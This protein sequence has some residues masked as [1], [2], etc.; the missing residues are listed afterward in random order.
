MTDTLL[1]DVASQVLDAAA[2]ALT[3]QTHA[4]QDLRPAIAVVQVGEQWAWDPCERLVVHVAGL[5]AH[6]PIP[7]AGPSTADLA[8]SPVAVPVADLVVTLLYAV[9][10]IE[11]TGKL[12]PTAD[13]TAAAGRLQAGAMTLWRGVA[14]ARRDGT[15]AP[16]LDDCDGAQLGRL[17]PV[18]PAGGYAGWELPVRLNLGAAS[19]SGS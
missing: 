6:Q 5:D 19:A 3:G 13:I 9:P 4:G 12:P 14:R 1:A 18:G 16:A 7:P 10:K 11:G 8:A 15:L 17:V 2:G